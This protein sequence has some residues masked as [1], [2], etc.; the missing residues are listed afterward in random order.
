MM[1]RSDL[2]HHG[3]ERTEGITE[4]EGHLAILCEVMRHLIAGDDVVAARIGEQRA[5]FQR[6]LTSWVDMACDTILQYPR[7]AFYAD[8][9]GL[10]KAFLDV[11]QLVLE[12]A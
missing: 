11:E 3:P 9:V 1:L 12:L 5:F 10:A 2:H 7:T 4:T 8:V 6:H